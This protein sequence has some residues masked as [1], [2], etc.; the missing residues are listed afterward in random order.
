M[1]T[2]IETPSASSEPGPQAAERYPA[3]AAEVGALPIHRALPNRQ[4]KTVG[5]WCFLDHAGPVALSGDTGMHVGPH[6]HIGL[7]TFT[8]MIEGSVLH[9]DSL[10]YE[11]VIRPGEVNLMT[12][13]RG[14]A[15][16]EDTEDTLLPGGRFHA[17][18]LWIALPDAHRDRAPAFE[19]YRNLPVH[20]DGGF[21]IT[22]LAGAAFDRVS[23]AQVYSPLVGLDFASDGPARLAMP[24]DPA[25]EY[26]VF[27]L[28]GDVAVDGAALEPNVLL[29]LGTGRDRLE[30]T[31]EAAARFIVLG[32]APFEE[33][34]LIWW[35]FVARSP[36][37][38][39][40]AADAWNAQR[41]FGDVQ[42]ETAPRMEAPALPP[43]WK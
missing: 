30:L 16:T 13:G 21:T 34:L 40:A 18:Q 11:Q 28:T 9:R 7:Q 27:A 5:A 12:A 23:P 15:H 17:V 33:D 4:R 29:Y 25:F 10:G 22:V 2:R 24:L 41:G 38:M 1:D 43:A 32:G 35:N 3:R 31:T 26:A 39:V 42:G 6:P 19:N 14:I 37:E 8:W 20:R 36:A